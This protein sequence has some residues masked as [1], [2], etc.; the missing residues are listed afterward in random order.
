MKLVANDKLLSLWSIIVFVVIATPLPP[1]ETVGQ[2]SYSDKIVHFVLF[3]VF[4]YLVAI[5]IKEKFSLIKTLLV[6]FAVSGA[7]AYFAE[8]IQLVIPGRDYSLLDWAAGAS[9]AV[10]FLIIFYARNRK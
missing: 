8:I 10:G 1:S 3:G 9:G 7:Y 6:A 2:L 5:N 4:A